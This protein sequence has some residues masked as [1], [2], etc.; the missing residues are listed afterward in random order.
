MAKPT[1]P[2][3]PSLDEPL[4]PRRALVGVGVV[5]V[6]GLAAWLA[7]DALVVTDEERVGE[8]VDD[9][10]G[11][12]GP[13]AV[14]R[15]LRWVDVERQALEVNAYGDAR[16]YLPGQGAE[17]EA[18]ARSALRRFDGTKLRMLRRSVEVSG[19]QAHVTLQ[20]LADDGMANV[21][22]AL[23]KRGDDWL[24]ARVYVH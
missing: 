23:R 14:T 6:L 16:S 8:L 11:T 12:M 15:G 24:L 3:P 18:R 13:D 22:F 19:D 5:V 1:R 17:L 4:V 2:K 10:A 7:Y 21:D 9:V 20:L